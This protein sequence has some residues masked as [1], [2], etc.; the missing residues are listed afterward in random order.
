VRSSGPGLHRLPAAGLVAG[1]QG[2][3][4]APRD[5]VPACCFGLAQA[6]LY[7][8]QDD[9]PFLRHGS[10]SKPSCYERCLDS[11]MND[12]L[13]HDTLSSTHRG[14]ASVMSQNMPN[15][16]N[17]KPGFG[18]LKSRFPGRA[19]GVGLLVRRASYSWTSH[20]L[21]ANQLPV[22][23]NA[24][25]RELGRTS[26]RWMRMGP[27]A[28]GYSFAGGSPFHRHRGAGSL[29]RNAGCRRPL[30]VVLPTAEPYRGGRTVP[31]RGS[32]RSTNGAEYGPAVASAA[33]GEV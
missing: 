25:A 8:R 19:L 26:L 7:H 28:V 1:Y 5:V 9:D 23:T 6:L 22:R 30:P 4:P 16:L 10:S 2:V 3:H 15:S 27:T 11:P 21:T 31:L 14:C 20:P 24:S 18:R 13:N 29:N 33:R 32:V 17:H 12:V